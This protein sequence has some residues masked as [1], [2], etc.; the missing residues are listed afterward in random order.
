MSIGIFF[1]YIENNLFLAALYRNCSESE[2]RC[3]NDKCIQ[4]KWRCD[5]DN[6]C[7]DLSD[8]DPN[9]CKGKQICF[10][11]KSICTVHI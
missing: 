1:N 2:F 5:H 11:R 4:G 8:E 9:Y 3:K 6:D 7:G 10:N